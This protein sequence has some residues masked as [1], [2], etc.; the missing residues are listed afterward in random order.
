M[1]AIR[2]TGV[3]QDGTGADDLIPS[4]NVFGHTEDEVYRGMFTTIAEWLTAG[5]LNDL[6]E[7]WLEE[8]PIAGVRVNEPGAA[9][10]WLESFREAAAYPYWTVLEHE[11][12]LDM[13]QP[14]RHGQ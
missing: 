11:S 8:N 1:P 12:L 3:V 2:C 10:E 9:Q 5:E 7:G 14:D 4:V 6:P 13:R